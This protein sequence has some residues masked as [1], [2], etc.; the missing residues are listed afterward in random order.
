MWNSYNRLLT[1]NH[2]QGIWIFDQIQ[3]SQ[4]VTEKQQDAI[5]DFPFG[6]YCSL[7]MHLGVKVS[8]NIA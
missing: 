2:G 1:G 7:S 5:T 8:I 6:A 3:L 4:K